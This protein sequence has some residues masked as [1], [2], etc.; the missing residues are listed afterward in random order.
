MPLEGRGQ[1]GAKPPAQVTTPQTAGTGVQG[2]SSTPTPPNGT[3][4]GANANNQPGQRPGPRPDWLWWQDDAVK[5]E[6]SLTA[7]QVRRIDFYYQQREKEMK[8]IVE[9][10]YKQRDELDKMA[11]ASVAS[12]EDFR[13]QVVR[14]QALASEISISRA[15]MSYRMNLALTAEQRAK[16]QDVKDRHRPGRGGDSPR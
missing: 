12:P 11:L 4:R 16:L 3:G 8:S 7:D 10:F 6:L 9:D 2:R 5:K 14:Y 15:V 13:L 1:Q